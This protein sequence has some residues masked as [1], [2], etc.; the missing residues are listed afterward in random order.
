MKNGPTPLFNKMK[1]VVQAGL[2]DVDTRVE[3]LKD[4]LPVKATLPVT[5]KL[6][7]K[8]ELPVKDKL[9]VKVTDV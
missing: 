6:P 1:D 8:D 3:E 9:P 2:R 5:D 7:V 4:E